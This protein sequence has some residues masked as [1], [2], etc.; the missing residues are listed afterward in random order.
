MMSK[1][2]DFQRVET[3]RRNMLITTD[4]IADLFETS[5]QTYYNYVKGNSAPHPRKL[6]KIKE[7]VRRLVFLAVEQEWPSS[8]LI[9]ARSHDRFSALKQELAAL[10]EQN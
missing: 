7:V 8:D 1:P 6:E 3:L 4:Q 10:A 9:G 5:R 2:L